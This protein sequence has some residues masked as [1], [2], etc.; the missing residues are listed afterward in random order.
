MLVRGLLMLVA[1]YCALLLVL[2]VFQARLVFLPD[3]AGRALMATPE[4]LGLSYRDVQIETEDGQT[5]HA[6]WLPHPAPRATL[7]FSHGN[8]GNVSHRLDSLRIFHELG[9][10]VLIYDYR[11]YGQ[12]SGRPSEAGIYR[13]GKAALR[14]LVDQADV[15]PA[16]I[17]LFGRS[18]GGAVA[19]RLA[20]EWPVAAL[21]VESSFTSVPDLAADIYWWLPARRLSRIR[22]PTLEFVSDSD[23]PTLIVHSRDDEIVPFSH[24]QRLHEAAPEPSRLLVLAGSHNTGFLDSAED[25]RAGLD[26]FLAEVISPSR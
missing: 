16:D 13:D 11:G 6:W 26:D 12:S 24:G 3:V 18:M 21:I 25:Y 2:F 23:Q 15:D 22:L 5:L 7:L 9:L 10:S 19:A 8:A 17:V 14:W 1:V 20:G 4:R